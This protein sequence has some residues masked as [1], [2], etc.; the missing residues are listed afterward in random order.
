MPEPEV[1]ERA[2]KDAEQGKSP[3]TQ[4]GEFVREEMHHV[5]QGKHGARSPQQAIAI[6]LSKARR[7]GVPL[8]PPKTGKTSSRTRAQAQRDI[9]KG[10]KS[11]ATKPSRTR[12]RAVSAALKREGHSAASYASLS[13]QAQRAARQRSGPSRH[14]SAMTAVHTQSLKRPAPSSPQSRPHPSK[15]PLTPLDLCGGGDPLYHHGWT[16]PSRAVAVLEPPR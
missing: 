13:R 14:Q 4:A 15:K 8:A 3:S 11:R 7:A 16:P 1:I 12:S 5:R 2:H 10:R 9:N 6:G